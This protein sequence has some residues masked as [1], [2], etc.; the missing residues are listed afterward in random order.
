MKKKLLDI[1]K[2]IWIVVVI[3]GAGYYFY[4]NYQK[5]SDY[6][7][8]ISILRLLASFFFLML[9]KLALS[10]MTRYS[11]KKIDVPIA[12]NDAL[13]ITSVTQL[14]KYLPGGIWHIAGKFGIYKARQISLK[15][16]TQAIIYENVWL[17]SSAFVMGVVLLMLSSG[18]ALCSV[19]QY[20][21]Q[22]EAQLI[23]S[24][25][26]PIL[27]VV[28]LY[29]FEKLFFKNN[30]III[31]DF[32]IKFIEMI[33][34]WISFGISFWF[35]FPTI[36]S[37]FVIPITGAFSLSWVI[38]YLA[39]FA[40][41]GIGV[42]EYLLTILLASFFSS[43]EIAIYATMHRLIWVLG[44]VILGAGTALIYGIP[45]SANEEKKE[46]IKE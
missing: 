33:I 3:I 25:L 39:V 43:Q 5:I 11:L 34:I 38:G 24:I 30:P 37:N 44:E 18:E 9:G 10:D 46:P 27:W 31:K 45:M 36:T 23:V 12:Y 16:S 28:G 26:L 19:S 20:F 4:K 7:E 17:L 13:T 6:L 21:C 32:I 15:K 41:G 14:G 40:P 8:T 22:S 29:V 1:F 35:V 2:W 42:R